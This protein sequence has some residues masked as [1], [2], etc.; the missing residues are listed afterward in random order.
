MSDTLPGY[1]GTGRNSPRW[2][3][4]RYGADDRIGSGNELTE[5]RTLEAL[6]LPTR[7][8]VIELTRLIE[9]GIPLY[10][11]RSWNQLLLG[12][13][14]LEGL[15]DITSESALGSFEEVVTQSYQIGC[16][17]DGLA[18]VTID[19][20]F[21]NGIHYRDEFTPVGMRELG[22]ENLR[23]W[24]SRGVCL[25]VAG[26]LGL[27]QLDPG[28]AITSD[29]LERAA[30]R[31]GVDV[32]AGDAVL[33]HTGWGQLWGVDNERYASTE[34]GVGWDAAHWLTDRRVSLVGADN[35]AFEPVP[36]ENPRRPFVVHQHVIAETGTH[37][38]E[39]VNTAELAAR[40]VSEFLFLMS[41]IKT[42]GSTASMVS[43]LAVI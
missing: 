14:S 21:Y 40:G 27:T 13:E 1:D 32:T 6:R 18:H 36:F 15:R 2:W 20:R 3:P 43:P 23:P 10:A 41:P 16:H 11:P 30:D 34:P 7:G 33:V 17:V 9:P 5:Q 22:I 42:S 24:V 4:S 28:F 12:H 29:H 8:E 35:W 37:I 38:L 25:D 39:N 31:Q 19:G 26:A